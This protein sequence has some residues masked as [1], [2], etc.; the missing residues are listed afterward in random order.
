[1]ISTSATTRFLGIAVASLA[2]LALCVLTWRIPALWMMKIMIVVWSANLLLLPLAF[3]LAGSWIL[4]GDAKAIDVDQQQGIGPSFIASL[5][6]VSCAV[7]SYVL[8]VAVLGRV[9]H[10]WWGG[11]S[12]GDPTDGLGR[13]AALLFGLIAVVVY[14][15]AFAFYRK[16]RGRRHLRFLARASMACIAYTSIVYFALGASHLVSWRA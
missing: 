4:R 15:A 7:V 8:S 13:S 16:L 6:L 14:G 12:Q 5:V 1:M 11:L 3:G 10:A 9:S 2:W